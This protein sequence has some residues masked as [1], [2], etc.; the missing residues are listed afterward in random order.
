MEDSVHKVLEKIRTHRVAMR[1]KAYFVLRA[2]GI[3]LLG[4]ISLVLATIVLSFVFISLH[5]SGELFLLGFGAEGIRTFFLLFP[6][7][8]M[9][10]VLLLMLLL[11]YLLRTYS[12]G[13]RFSILAVFGTLVGIAAILSLLLTITPFHEGLENQAMHGSLPFLAPAYAGLHHPHPEAGE[14][15]GVITTVGTST[16]TIAHDDNDNS[17]DDGTSTVA[18]PPGTDVTQLHPGDR[19]Y[20]GGH[21]SAGAIHAYGLHSFPKP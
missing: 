17:P 2:L 9:L 14:Y 3:A 8:L 18:I 5:R 12:S 11:E 13:Y 15:W 16:I 20:I 6:W 7:W 4:L 21:F 19:I 1:S 10:V